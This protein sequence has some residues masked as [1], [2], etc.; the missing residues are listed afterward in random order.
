M[1]FQRS[2]RSSEPRRADQVDDEITPHALADDEGHCG[3]Q[4]GPEQIEQPPE[5]EPKDSSSSKDQGADGDPQ[6]RGHDVKSDQY[7]RRPCCLA[8][9]FEQSSQ[10][11]ALDQ[12]AE[13]RP[14]ECCKGS[15]ND[16][17]KKDGSQGRGTQRTAWTF[18]YWSI[19]HRVRS[20]PPRGGAREISSVARGPRASGTVSCAAA[21]PAERVGP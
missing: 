11:F 21:G 12:I 4:K 8:K 10:L 2:F 9:L 18:S 17:S 19:C 16:G 3:T 14:A 13:R 7:R 1:L 15:S 6:G 20:L 5:D